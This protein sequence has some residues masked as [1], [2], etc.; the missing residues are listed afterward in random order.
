MDD[1]TQIFYVPPHKLLRYLPEMIDVFGDRRACLGREIT[2][3]FEE[4]NRGRLSDIL[5][6]YNVR[7]PKGEMVLLIEGK[8]R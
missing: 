3:K 2:K 7:K 6:A 1:A 4:F 5:E 8:T